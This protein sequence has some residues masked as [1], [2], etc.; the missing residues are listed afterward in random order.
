MAEKTAEHVKAII[1]PDITRAQ[2]DLP[3]APDPRFQA[4]G[5]K[6]VTRLRG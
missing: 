3:P 6:K 4:E 2:Q 1:A 5:R